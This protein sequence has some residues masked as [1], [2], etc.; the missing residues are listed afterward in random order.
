MAWFVALLIVST[1]A[2]AAW[3]AR[4]TAA[5]GRDGGRP[6]TR[7]I[8]ATT[9]LVFTVGIAAFLRY[10]HATPHHAMYIDE[11]WYA[12]AACNLTRYGRLEICEEKW[13]GRSCSAFEK[14]P[15]W[16]VLMSP[17]AALRGCASSIGIDLNR[18]LGTATPL[19]VALAA[20]LAGAG[21][22]TAAF[23]AF[24][25]AVNPL[26]V[27]WSATG[28]TNVAAAFALL[29]ALC[30]AVS[31]LRNGRVSGAALATSAFALATAIRPESLVAALVAAGAALFAYGARGWP[32]VVAAVAI[33]TAAAIAAAGASFLWTMNEEISNGF[34]FDA[35]NVARNVK[36][37]EG[38]LHGVAAL[39]AVAGAATMLRDRRHRSA[40]LLIGV[41]I[42]AAAVALA[43]DR[44]NERMLLAAIA[45]TAPLTAFAFARCPPLPLHL[46]AAVL[47]ALW[48][49]E[50]PA[51]YA[52]S[53]TQR[54]E[55]RIVRSVARQTFPD[56]A[57][58]IAEQPTV[59]AATGLA[60]V[61]R[62]E[63]ALRKPGELTQ[64]ARSGTAVFY[65][66]DM[67][68]DENFAGGSGASRCRRMKD[69]FAL[70][71]VVEEHLPPHS[72]VLYAVVGQRRG[73]IAQE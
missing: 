29:V 3:C 48:W 32:R 7:S 10:D 23:A 25:V 13:T 73:T 61:M 50:L 69:E 44:F 60:R 42:V 26:H 24:T 2:S 70:T 12:E 49:N 46:T 65:L 30:G 36:A 43:Y 11:P 31:Y 39:F 34:F 22:W 47:A 67:Y 8:G 66:D 55:T 33:A 15:G 62:T 63:E 35:S 45:A 52:P 72:Y 68:C 20:A 21:W 40:L 4:E 56:D 71:A 14:A 18:V 28:E 17:W 58:F 27:K 38:H 59:L 37:L 41:G 1:V 57:L 53:A 54:L 6:S 9:A 64:L 19:V 16:P 5:R 51:G